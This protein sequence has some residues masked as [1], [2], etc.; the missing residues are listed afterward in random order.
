MGT[1]GIEPNRRP[2]YII[3]ATDLQSAVENSPQFILPFVSVTMLCLALTVLEFD[4][5]DSAYPQGVPRVF[6]LI[7]TPDYKYAL[8]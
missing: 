8:M 2:L 3:M 4:F 6:F 1:E 5:T 7:T